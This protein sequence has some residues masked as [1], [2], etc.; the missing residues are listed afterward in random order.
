MAELIRFAVFLSPVG[1]DA[2]TSTDEAEP[3][4]RFADP[5]QEGSLL[6]SRVL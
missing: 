5:S 4:P 3:T 6:V 1:N 2:Q